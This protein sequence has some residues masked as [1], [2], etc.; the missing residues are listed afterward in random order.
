MH[1]LP[2]S[3]KWSWCSFDSTNAFYLVIVCRGVRVLGGLFVAT[4]FD[5]RSCF[6]SGVHCWKPLPLKINVFS[7][8]KHLRIFFLMG[9]D[10]T[11]RLSISKLIICYNLTVWPISIRANLETSCFKRGHSFELFISSL[12]NSL[13]D[14]CLWWVTS[15]G[16]KIESNIDQLV[17]VKS[18]F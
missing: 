2:L 14:S 5:S 1:F 11:V 18:N 7:L 13:I 6:H 12:E 17:W 8:T 10:P 15:F 9:V 3:L 4:N 16:Q